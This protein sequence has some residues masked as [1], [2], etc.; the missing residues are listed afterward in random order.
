M[1]SFYYLN[2]CTQNDTIFD[3]FIISRIKKFGICIKNRT[4]NNLLFVVWFRVQTGWK[5]L[6]EKV[7]AELRILRNNFDS[8]AHKNIFSCSTFYHLAVIIK[9]NYYYE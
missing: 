8:R 3:T 6:K 5:E 1:P 9:I 7:I 2:Y 4:L